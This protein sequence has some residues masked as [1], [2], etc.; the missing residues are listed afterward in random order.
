MR[1]LVITTVP[2]GRLA[3]MPRLLDHGF[4]HDRVER[5]A[6]GERKLRGGTYSS[7]LLGEVF[8]DGSGIGWLRSMRT[9]DAVALP[10]TGL[11]SDAAAENRARW[12]EA[13]ADDCVPV[14]VGP[15]EMVARLR[16]VLRPRC[17]ATLS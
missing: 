14:D 9:H 13:G 12:L 6:E 11:L 16:A 3:F 4:D 15:R 8:P 17:A 2:S 1:L 7:I 5:L 10:V